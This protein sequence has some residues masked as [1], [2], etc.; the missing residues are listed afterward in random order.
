MRDSCKIGGPGKTVQI[1]ESKFGKR[2]YHRGHRV[3][4]QWVFGGIEEGSRKCFLISVE[5]RSEAALLPLIE[6]CIEPET[7]ILSDCWKAYTNLEKHN[8]NHETVN[9]SKEFVNK[10]RKHTNKMEGQWRYVKASLPKFGVRK[11]MYSG[12]LAEFLWRYLHKDD[13]DFIICFYYRYQEN[14]PPK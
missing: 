12:Y 6:K 4:G 1:D 5:E 9:H 7:L 8:Y 13:D 10:Y 2:K 11:Y 14:L 3:E